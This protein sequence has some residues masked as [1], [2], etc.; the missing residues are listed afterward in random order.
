MK[1]TIIGSST[2][3]ASNTNFDQRDLRCA[4]GKFATGV[5]VVAYEGDAGPWGVTVNSFTSVSMD[6][7]L[8]LISISRNARAAKGLLNAPFTIN[9]LAEPQRDLAMHFAGKPLDEFDIPWQSDAA[10][11]ALRDTLACFECEPW[12]AVDAGDHILFLGR[13]VAYEYGSSSPLVFHEG[14]FGRIGA[15]NLQASGERVPASASVQ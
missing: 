8:V 3:P 14:R 1:T 2:A 4:F 10:V 7:P 6:P 9:V 15:A 13:V 12:Q 5:T 11:P